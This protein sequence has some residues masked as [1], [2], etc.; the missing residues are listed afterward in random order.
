MSH[1]ISYIS[2]LACGDWLT[3]TFEVV[4]K[5]WLLRILNLHTFDQSDDVWAKR[6]HQPKTKK[7][8]YCCW[9]HC[10]GCRLPFHLDQLQFCLN[11]SGSLVNCPTRWSLLFIFGFIYFPS[12]STEKYSMVLLCWHTLVIFPD[13]VSRAPLCAVSLQFSR[14]NKS[15]RQKHR[16]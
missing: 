3:A 1:L 10:W 16:F 14:I 2:T 7:R 4:H 15:K 13:T 6:Q 8:P 5:E 11:S 12:Q 9:K